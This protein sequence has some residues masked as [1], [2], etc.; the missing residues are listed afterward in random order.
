MIGAVARHMLPRLSGVAHLLVNRPLDQKKTSYNLV[1][2][3]ITLMICKTRCGNFNTQRTVVY[4]GHSE[5]WT[6]N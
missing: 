3:R 1:G 6:R 2:S 5:H 4:T